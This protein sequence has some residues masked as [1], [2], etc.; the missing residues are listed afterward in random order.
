MCF[1]FFLDNAGLS[2]RKKSHPS[3]PQQYRAMFTEY[4]YVI[5]RR[6]PH[7]T[8][9]SLTESWPQLDSSTRMWCSLP[10][11]QYALLVEFYSTDIAIS[12][13]FSTSPQQLIMKDRNRMN[14]SDSDF[15]ARIDVGDS[16]IFFQISSIWEWPN[17]NAPARTRQKESLAAASFHRK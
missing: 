14:L 11:K 4:I 7:L 3:I 12:K 10:Q 15:S 1:L 2:S 17:Y 6:N 5:F 16:L 9:L 13:H 8:E